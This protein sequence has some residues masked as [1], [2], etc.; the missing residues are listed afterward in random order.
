M[1]ILII[2]N[3]GSKYHE[4]GLAEKARIYREFAYNKLGNK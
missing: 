1:S 2:Y 3:T 4:I